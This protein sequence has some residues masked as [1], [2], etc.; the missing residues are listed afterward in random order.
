MGPDNVV[1]DVAAPVCDDASGNRTPG[2]SAEGGIRPPASPGGL[3]S[4]ADGSA[5]A[6]GAPTRQSTGLYP[7]FNGR[8]AGFGRQIAVVG[9]GGTAQQVSCPPAAET[10]LP[11]DANEAR[12]GVN[13]VA[14]GNSLDASRA[15]GTTEGVAQRALS[16][17]PP[18]PA[19]RTAETAVA[20]AVDPGTAVCTDGCAGGTC[21]D[22][23]ARTFVPATILAAMAPTVANPY[24]NAAGGT[25][26]GTVG[27]V[28]GA[29]GATV[30]PNNITPAAAGAAAAGGE[31]P[32]DGD[33]QGAR[34][35]FMP[36]TF[37]EEEILGADPRL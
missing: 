16:P 15:E 27:V 31:P 11:V 5:D 34:G 23:H 35:H 10:A 18:C 8:H 7:L 3:N 20:S 33:V 28:G 12:R 6:N 1:G 22:G 19:L 30:T 32:T 36:R 29:A 4:S 2:F 25:A 21:I 24:T 9:R 26:A 37:T 13:G 17:P 14:V